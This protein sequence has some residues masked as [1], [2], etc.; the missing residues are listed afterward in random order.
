MKYLIFKK[1]FLVLLLAVFAVSCSGSS[2]GGESGSGSSGGGSGEGAGG[3]GGAGG[4]AETIPEDDTWTI[5]GTVAGSGA[6]G[7]KVTLSGAATSEAT[8]VADGKYSFTG[9][10]SGNYTLTPAKENTV[11]TPVS[12]SLTLS[13]NKELN[14][15]SAAYQSLSVSST[16]A[17]SKSIINCDGNPSLDGVSAVVGK[18]TDATCEESG[19]KLERLFLSFD[20]SAISS[21]ATLVSAALSFNQ[22]VEKTP[23]SVGPLTIDHVDYG[24]TIEPADWNNVTV[25]NLSIATNSSADTIEPVTIDTD[26]ASYV[27]SNIADGR[28]Q[29]LLRFPDAVGAENYI[30]VVDPSL[31]ITYYQF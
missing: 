30:T 4:S 15:T 3:E 26:L 22:G 6:S 11:F 19:V 9:L 31:L 7:V 5:S 21:S 12:S 16:S 18:K 28:I 27:A 20:L 1:S 23:Y 17:N 10:A 24:A 14:F 29:F 25:E 8:T 2:P 13:E